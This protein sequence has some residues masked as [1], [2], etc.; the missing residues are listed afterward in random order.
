MKFRLVY[1]VFLCALCAV[2]LLG[3]K[4]GRASQAQKGN[5]GAPGDETQ[6][7]QPKTCMS[8]HNQGPITASV[9]I[10]VLD[11]NNAPVTQYTPGQQYTARVTITA[12]GLDLGGYGF[13]MIALRASDNSDLD[14]FTDSNPNNYKLASIP[15][16]RTY[17]EH[18]NIST[19][20]TFN[21][22]WTAPPAGTGVVKF[23]ASGNGVNKNGQT[24]GDGA[25]VA[26]LT[27]TEFGTTTSID[28]VLDFSA[29]ATVTP[30]PA[31]SESRFR[32]QVPASGDYRLE[33]FDLAG[34]LVWSSAQQV[35]DSDL[36]IEISMADW[37]PGI[38]LLRA[39]GA[40]ASAIVKVLKL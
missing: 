19:P 3:N 39:S 13:Q 6:S 32:A 18:D 36:N 9:A 38:Y 28:N 22:R 26:S 7:G 8:C 35:Q 37:V 2:V 20:N 16:G 31:R 11:A 34:H 27:L 14:G 33:A 15:G 1:M 4:N 10:N 12:S 29:K 40:G 17:A 23:Y 24:S 30:N 21:V 5:T 25:G